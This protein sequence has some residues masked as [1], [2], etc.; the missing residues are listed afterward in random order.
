MSQ[1]NW[2]GPW[3]AKRVLEHD[4]V[5]SANLVEGNIIFI[6]RHDLSPCVVATMSEA[7]VTEDAV[8]RAIGDRD[9]IDFVVNIPKD[10]VL[11]GDALQVAKDSNFALGGVGDLLRALTME[12][13]SEYYHPTIGFIERGLRQHDRVA[14]F[15]RVAD[16]CYVIHRTQGRDLRAVFLYEYDLTADHIRVARDRYGR[17]DLV[18]KTN[19]NGSVTEAAIEVAKELGCRVFMW[20]E[21][22]GAINWM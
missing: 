22:L 16:L 8:R 14:D 9:D 1:D 15:T 12:D 21:F 7:V 4:K 11:Q 17:F 10:G 13:V 3:I 6:D 18:V 20:G 5:A 2:S 19:P